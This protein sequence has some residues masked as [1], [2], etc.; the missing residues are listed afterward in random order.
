MRHWAAVS[1]FRFLVSILN[2]VSFAIPV[3]RFLPIFWCFHV[4]HIFHAS[5]HFDACS[6]FRDKSYLS[7]VY[8]W[9]LAPPEGLNLVFGACFPRQGPAMG[10]APLLE[11]IPDGEALSVFRGWLRQENRLLKDG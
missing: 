6:F 2:A 9:I 4:F 7:I 5:N 1:H 3:A 8:S 10:L 11:G